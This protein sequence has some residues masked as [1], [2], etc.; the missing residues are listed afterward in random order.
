MFIKD[1]II[2]K[3]IKFRRVLRKIPGFCIQYN[4]APLELNILRF[5]HGYHLLLYPPPALAVDNFRAALYIIIR[6]YCHIVY[7]GYDDF[8][9]FSYTRR[10]FVCM[11][12]FIIITR[13]AK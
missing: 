9:P 5:I 10:L 11:D 7:T 2:L 3:Y 13:A 6:I 8:C 1:Y 4:I 12:F